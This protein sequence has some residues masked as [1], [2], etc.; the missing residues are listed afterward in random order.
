MKTFINQRKNLASIAL[1]AAALLG[2]GAIQAQAQSVTFNFADA[3]SDGWA[4]SGF[5][6][7]P[8]AT[9]TPIG[10]QNY[11]SIAFVGFQDAN[12]ATGYAGLPSALN[13]AFNAAMYAAINDPSGYDI[14]YNYSFNSASL[15]GATF[16]QLGIYVNP[17]SY[18]VQD[19]ST[20]NQ[21]SFSG[22]QLASGQTFSGT[23]T[24][25][26]GTMGVNDPNAA[27][28]SFF[29]LGLIDNSNAT[30]GAIDYT[31]ISITPVATPEPT[32]LALAGLGGLSMLFL[33][34][35]KA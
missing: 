3:T 18:Y 4:N 1:T 34:R 25:N 31:D 23:V 6:A 15:T 2:L 19:Y 12:V 22:T 26:L 21:V 11:I 33:R 17:G 5:N 32:S 29:K 10:G 7:T 16:L 9:I 24:E 28:E 20:P 27:T 30:G 35:R 14:S 13:T 8:A